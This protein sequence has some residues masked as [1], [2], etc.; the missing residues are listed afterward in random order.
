MPMNPGVSDLHIDQALTDVSVAYF[1][2]STEFIADQVFPSSPSDKKSNLFPKYSKSDWRRTN[3]QKRAPGTETPGTG[4]SNTTDRF[5]CEVYGVHV[6]IEDQERANAD[7]DWD[8]DADAS[9]K[10]TQELLILKDQIWAENFFT[11]GVWDVQHQGV[12]SAPSGTQFLQ[13]DQSGSD[14]LSNFTQWQTDFKLSTTK[15]IKWMVMGAD[16]WVAIQNHPAILDSIKFTQLGYINQQLVARFFNIDK[17]LVAYASESGGPSIP[18]A[19]AQ[20]AAATYNFI[21]DPKS[22]LFG[23]SPAKPSKFE[24]SAGYTWN[25]SGYGA[26]N[27]SG[28]TIRQFR[29]ERIRSDRVEGEA[30]FDMKQVSTD[31]AVFLEDVV[32]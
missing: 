32:A 14:P 24:P 4:W 7:N 20:D 11:T 10:V 21:A 16:V 8:L 19:K 15:N 31:C 12:A 3:A 9:R 26:K 28:L 13:W 6:D 27:K 18:D 22:V 17:L 30:A 25:W 2:D 1:Q 23:Y 5:E 29:E